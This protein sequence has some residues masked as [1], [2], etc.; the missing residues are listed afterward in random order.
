MELH[1]TVKLTS[2]APSYFSALFRGAV[3]F[4]SSATLLA[5]PRCP[6]LF[7]L[8]QTFTSSDHVWVRVIHSR[9]GAD[10]LFMLPV[11]FSSQSLFL[12]SSLSFS[13]IVFNSS[14]V[15]TAVCFFPHLAWLLFFDD[16]DRGVTAPNMSL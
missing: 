4:H 5:A 2:S 13:S 15:S 8:I 7:I 1:K 9:D 12:H 14:T 6:R 3:T 10:V 16:F 11:G